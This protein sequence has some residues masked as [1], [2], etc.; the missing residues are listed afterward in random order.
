ML[1]PGPK[2][3][4]V[5]P[6]SAITYT[7][8]GNSVYIVVPRKNAEGVPEKDAKGE[9]QRIVDRRFVETG[10]RRDGLVIISKGLKAGEQVVSGGQLKLD[11]GAHVAISTDQTL[12]AEQNSQPQVD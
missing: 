5:I 9:I 1:L 12:Q 3:Q 10:E 6:E 11:A 7:L 8:Y 4:V 2:T